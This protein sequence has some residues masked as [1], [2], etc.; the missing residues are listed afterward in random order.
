MKQVRLQAVV[1]L[2][3]LFA[4]LPTVTSAQ[5]TDAPRVVDA[6][7]RARNSRNIDAALALFADDARISLPPRSSI[8]FT[9]KAEIRGFLETMS[10]R[11]P[12]L[13]TSN[14]NVA[15]STVT[16][17]ERDAGTRS[18][19]NDL[20]V[21][22]IVRDGKIQSIQYRPASASPIRANAVVGPEPVPAAVALGSL[23][24]AGLGLLAIASLG[25]RR[26]RSAST[27]SG[28]LMVGLD[29][30]RTAAR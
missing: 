10:M 23:L 4:T 22:V 28:K 26:R 29:H 30:W 12:P 15:G 19:A 3:L 6:Y 17:N 21:Q 2:V 5:V 13:I 20:T 9:G 11:T 1:L 14:R 25:S 8:T 7:E 27:L 24:A 18:T 16:W